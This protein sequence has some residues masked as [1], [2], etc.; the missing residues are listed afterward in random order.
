MSLILTSFTSSLS[1]LLP[2][3]RFPRLFSPVKVLTS[4]RLAVS[5]IP[6]VGNTQNS[7]YGCHRLGRAVLAL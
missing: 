1:T 5:Q 4:K 7:R 6:M 3:P 2:A